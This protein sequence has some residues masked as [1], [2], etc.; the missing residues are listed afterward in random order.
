[1]APGIARSAQTAGEADCVVGGLFYRRRGGQRG[2]VIVDFEKLISTLPVDT[3]PLGPG[4]RMEFV[5]VGNEYPPGGD[6][7]KPVM[8]GKFNSLW[9]RSTLK[10][11]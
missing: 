2:D 8:E 5:L 6:G 1:M 7:W 9:W 11:G 3:S 10:A 4:E